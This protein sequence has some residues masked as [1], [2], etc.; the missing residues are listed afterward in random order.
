MRRRPFYLQSDN[1][2]LFCWLHDTEA[3]TGHGVLICPPIG[4]EQV[5]S[6]RALRHLA[7][8][9]AE[10]GF[11]TL[12]LDYHGTGDSAGDLQEPKRHAV[13]LA[14]LRS[15]V[16]WLQSELA[17]KQ[18]TLIGVRFGAALATEIASELPLA[19]LVLWAPVIKGRAYIRELKA[20]AMAT[21]ARRSRAPTSR[22]PAS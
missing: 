16:T 14:N 22:R 6:H 13:W 7:D 5:H 12:R 17:C 2:P 10:A 9:L 11:P 3:R 15:A 19:D 1:Q 8:A 21:G 20:L 4:H 18:I